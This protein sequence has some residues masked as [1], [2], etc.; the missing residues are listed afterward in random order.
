[1][2][3]KLSQMEEIVEK[4]IDHLLQSDCKKR[5][6]AWLQ[7]LLLNIQD[8]RGMLDTILRTDGVDSTDT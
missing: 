2:K 5:P 4:T 7:V 3:N 6:I 8:L 1:M